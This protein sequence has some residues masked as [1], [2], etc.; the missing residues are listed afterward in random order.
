M[1]NEVINIMAMNQSVVRME[2]HD[3]LA[4]MITWIHKG[5]AMFVSG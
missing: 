5:N 1:F 2:R 4:R 3:V